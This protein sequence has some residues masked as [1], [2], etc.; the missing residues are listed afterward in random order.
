MSILFWS[1]SVAQ[2]IEHDPYEVGDAGS[3]PARG[4]SL[5]RL[6]SLLGWSL[7]LFISSI[8]VET[9]APADRLQTVNKGIQILRDNDP[10][11]LELE[12]SGY[13]LVGES[14]GARLRL[15]NNGDMAIYTNAI[16]RV[17][18]DEVRIEELNAD[19]AD[20][21]FDLELVNNPD[22]PYTPATSRALPSIGNIRSLWR[23]E[24]RIFGAISSG[25]L[26]GALATS[27]R[28]NL[29]ELDFA[30]IL[31]DHRGKGIGKALAAAAILE[32]VK[33]GIYLFGTG[34]AS[35]NEASFGTVTSLGFSV[36]ERWRSYKRPL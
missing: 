8:V 30:S 12:S 19:F 24:N 31:R 16:N 28:E 1:A 5:G 33:Q 20:A 10:R 3:N 32:W 36:E 29:V 26:I 11:C 23:Q 18:A 17:L 25:V 15:G 35:V 22:Y 27:R 21:L 14:W 9:K 34:G 7:P 4:I 6:H 2:R 13:K